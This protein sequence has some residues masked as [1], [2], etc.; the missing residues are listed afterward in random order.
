MTQTN[1]V[2][3][4]VP[5]RN[6]RGEHV[7]SVLVKRSYRIAHRQAAQRSEVDAPFRLTD[8]YYD[9][10]DPEWSTVQ[11]EGE[12]APCKPMTD[13]VVIG[14]AYAP[15]G[16]P[17]H[18]MTVGVSVGERRKSLLV[19]GDRVCHHRD[20]QAPTFSEP[21]PFTDM[22]IRYDRAY[23]GHDERSDPNIP[24]HYPRNAMGKGVVLR[25]V[26]EVVQGLPLL[27]IEDPV[28]LLTPER[29]VIEDPQRWHLQPV[30][31]G[32]GWRQRTWYPR[33]ALLGAY[34]PFLD[35]GT[36]TAEERAGV[37]PANHVALAKQS[38][39]PPFEAHF[40]NGASLDMIF[41]TLN[42]DEDIHLLGL[43]PQGHLQFRLPG[44]TPSVGLDLGEGL[45]PLQPRM[46]TVSIRPDDLAM[47]IV[48]QAPQVYPGY[49]W[50]PQMKRL[51]A[52]VA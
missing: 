8:A 19:C 28:D 5:G 34:P 46:H 4:I 16:T 39:L 35:A 18:Q 29:V 50:L 17:V 30:P 40:C 52:E 3:Q 7:F 14:K 15:G 38:R 36:V 43:T 24:F 2:V 37:L 21:Q 42:A 26:K 31:Q 6:E 32:L 27:N 51:L 20:G 47:D 10:G 13:V 45:Q 33:S 11:H 49:A 25:N 23:G 9:N 44:E 1:G 41:R 12:L 48:W 22:E